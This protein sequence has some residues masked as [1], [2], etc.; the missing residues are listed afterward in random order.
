MSA[1]LLLNADF[2]P[3]KTLSWQHSVGLVVRDQAM[4]VDT[5]PGRR[6]RSARLELPWPAVI[7]LRRYVPVRPVPGP[8]RHNVLLRDGHRCAYCGLSH[9]ELEP[10]EVLT[11][12]HVVPRSRA[13][14]GKVVDHEGRSIDVNGWRNVVAACPPCNHRKAAR[15]PE[16]AHMTLRVT[17]RIPRPAELW[18]KGRVPASWRPYLAKTAA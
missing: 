3:L 14:R 10:G 7:A 5:V 13:V 12:D 4:V 9:T 17:P 6:V 18:A 8:T 2:T 1:V 15:T 16:E 11:M